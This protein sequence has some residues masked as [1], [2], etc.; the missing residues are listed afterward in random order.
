MEE[1]FIFPLVKLLNL[2][3]AFVSM[4]E[5]SLNVEILIEG[6]DCVVLLVEENAMGIQI[7]CFFGMSY[8]VSIFL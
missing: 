5:K 1:L 6:F 8:E 7:E 2:E 3:I 4:L